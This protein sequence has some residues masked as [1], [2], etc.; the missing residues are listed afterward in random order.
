MR[1]VWDALGQ[2]NRKVLCWVLVLVIRDGGICYGSYI[3]AQG[4]RYEC[5]SHGFFLR[6]EGIGLGTSDG[7]Y[8]VVIFNIRIV[9]TLKKSHVVIPCQSNYD[10]RYYL[11][12]YDSIYGFGYR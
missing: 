8:A 2:V 7:L 4:S 6:A 11:R 5:R 3:L 10:S 9:R 1:V 12:Y